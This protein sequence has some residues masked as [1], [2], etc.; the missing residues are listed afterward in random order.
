MLDP[1]RLLGGTRCVITAIVVGQDTRLRLAG[2]QSPHT[3]GRFV[4]W[5]EHNLSVTAAVCT[6]T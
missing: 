4:S 2:V 5:A 1:R 6:G 3:P